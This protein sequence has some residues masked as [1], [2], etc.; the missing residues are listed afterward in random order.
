MSYG[1]ET[2]AASVLTAVTSGVSFTLPTVDLTD[3]LLKLPTALTDKMY[4]KITGPATSDLTSG[5]VGGAGVFD[6]LMQTIG[7]HLTAERDKNRITGNEYTQAY[8]QLVQAAMGNA[9]QFT[10]GKEQAF[11]EAQ[12]AQA[13]SITARVQLETAKVELAKTQLEALTV[14]A[15][16]ALATVKLASESIA[17]G[18]SKYQLDNLLPASLAKLNAETTS[19]ATRNTLLASQKTG[20]DTSNSTASY[21]LSYLM[22]VQLNTATTA[23]QTAEYNRVTLQPQQFA[24]LVE[25]TNVQRAQ[26]AD[27]RQD[28][29]G[30][31][32]LIKS[33]KDLYAQQI[34]SY[35]RDS[36]I[37]ATK[38]FTDAWTVQKTVDDGLAAPGNFSNTSLDGILDHIKF[39]N[40]LS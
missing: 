32:G 28:S 5:T 7:A 31:A 34:L 15:N 11:W 8:I 13:A 35:K 36:E 20:Q 21:N 30:V 9:V 3:P 37:K 29:Q 17:Y 26:T 14:K 1:A 27:L 19:E 23:Q 39:N 16:Y 38:V 12:K 10:L 2:E 22:P 18:I 24:L 4:A 6:T 33:Q 25:Q 40:G